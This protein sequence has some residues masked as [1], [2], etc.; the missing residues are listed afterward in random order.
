[1]QKYFFLSIVYASNDHLVRRALWT[2]LVK[3]S[4]HASSVPWLV[5]GDFN[6]I[7]NM[8]EHSDYF[9]GIRLFHIK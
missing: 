5:L 4:S 1:M 6:V 7:L 8:K 9:L 3:V 2:D